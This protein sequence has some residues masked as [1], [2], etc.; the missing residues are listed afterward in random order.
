MQAAGEGHEQRH[1]QSGA[2]Q[3]GV[4]VRVVVEGRQ[5]VA[6]GGEILQAAVEVM[7]RKGRIVLCG[8]IADYNHAEPAAGLRNTMR[9]DLHPDAYLGEGQHH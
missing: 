1:E 9:L 5:R 6:V 2:D 8:Q 4:V 3:V 7:A